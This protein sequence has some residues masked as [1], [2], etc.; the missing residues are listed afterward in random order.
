M[1]TA[2][3]AMSLLSLSCASCATTPRWNT[4]DPEG[5]R[6][7]DTIAGGLR[8]KWSVRVVDENGAPMTNF[9]VRMWFERLST[10]PQ[11][12][13][14]KTDENGIFTA[15]GRTEDR[16]I[17][18][19]DD[20]DSYRSHFEYKFFNYKDFSNIDGDRWLPWNPTN[21]IVVRPKRNPVKMVDPFLTFI[22]LWTPPHIPLDVSL[23][24]DCV[25]CDYLPPY[26]NGQT[27]DFSVTIS[28]SEN[29]TNTLRFA[30]VDD[31]G[32]FIVKPVRFAD[33]CLFV[34]E[35]EAPETGYAPEF[36][37]SEPCVTLKKFGARDI[38]YHE[39][40]STNN[41]EYVIFRSRVA[42]DAAGTI[43]NAT[44]GLFFADTIGAG[45]S[46]RSI[47]WRGDENGQRT[48]GWLDLEYRFNPDPTSRSLEWDSYE[49]YSGTGCR[50]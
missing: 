47:M 7:L 12:A 20:T 17:I 41:P 5:I 45:R 11:K 8:C 36:V 30:A 34:T 6:Y 43:T 39:W 10:F 48:N 19:S 23:G 26:G 16:V 21:T 46:F 1:K 3:F 35:Y 42:K 18:S 22:P 31:G 37:L 50:F 13:N 32:G 14:G 40:C 4:D 9:P 44:H 25:R 27:A 38:P 15:E 29:G 28:H 33:T 49:W 24:F 2:I